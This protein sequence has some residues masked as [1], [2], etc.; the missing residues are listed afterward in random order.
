M[1]VYL[2]NWFKHI[3]IFSIFRKFILSLQLYRTISR[4]MY[5]NDLSFQLTLTGKRLAIE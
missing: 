4:V 2:I 3:E 1:Y 5:R